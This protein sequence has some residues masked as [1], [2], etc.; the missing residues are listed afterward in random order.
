MGYTFFKVGSYILLR[1]SLLGIP[2]IIDLGGRGGGRRQTT[3]VSSLQAAGMTIR[4][5]LIVSKGKIHFKIAEEPIKSYPLVGVVEFWSEWLNHTANQYQPTSSAPCKDLPTRS[6]QWLDWPSRL[7]SS[8]MIHLRQYERY[9]GAAPKNF[10]FHL[11]LGLLRLDPGLHVMAFWLTTA[12]SYTRMTTVLAHLS[13]LY[14]AFWQR[15]S[16]FR[17]KGRHHPALS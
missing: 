1:P 14:Y 9:S 7:A 6:G 3:Y 2:R 4:N 10:Y 15:M 13:T 11:A 8:S 17:M 12:K 16:S 5:Y